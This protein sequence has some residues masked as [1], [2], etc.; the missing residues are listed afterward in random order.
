MKDLLHGFFEL[1]GRFRD[2][3]PN[4]SVVMN[5]HSQSHSYSHDSLNR[6]HLTHH[7]SDLSLSSYMEKTFYVIV[8][9]DL[10]CYHLIMSHQLCVV[11]SGIILLFYFLV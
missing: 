3:I 6:Q 5:S 10:A 11:V 1:R 7:S 2:D 4:R 9:S 8:L